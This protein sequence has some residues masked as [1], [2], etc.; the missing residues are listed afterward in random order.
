MKFFNLTVSETPEGDKALEINVFGVI[1]PGFFDDGGV[2][3]KEIADQLAE[4]RDAKAITVR[5]N[6]LGGDAFAGVAIYNLLREH[7]AAQDGKLTSIVEGIAA[8]AASVIAMAGKTVMGR[9]SMMMVHNPWTFAAGTADDLRKTAEVLDAVGESLVAIY[10]AKTGKKPAELR[11]LLN[12][13]TWMSADEAKRNGFADEVSD[14]PVKAKADGE[15]VVL[16]GVPFPRERMP[17]PILAM[18]APPSPDGLSRDDVAGGIETDPDGERVLTILLPVET[19]KALHGARILLGM[20]AP[21]LLAALL[22]E[23]RDSVVIPPL[24]RERLAAE[25]PALLAELIEEGRRVGHASGVAEGHA[26]GHAAGVVA[27]RARLKAIDELPVRGHAE[28][29]LAAKYGEKPL[30][31]EALAVQALHA[32]REIGADL[33]AARRTEAAVITTVKPTSPEENDKLSRGRAEEQAAKQIAAHANAR[34][35]GAR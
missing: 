23:G 11:A 35:G 18:A 3:S 32:E 20:G 6:S 26:A 5:I 9:G 1:E 2:R 28:L 4:H 29:V 25:A 13:E 8:S 27:E 10:K 14:A 12:A 15:L 33:L 34:P 19:P 31:A 24:T 16:N 22:S 17:A 7:P 30:T 21:R